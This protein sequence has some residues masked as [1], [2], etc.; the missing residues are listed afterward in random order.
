MFDPYPDNPEATSGSV[1]FSKRRATVAGDGWNPENYGFKADRG[2]KLHPLDMPE[3]VA[4]H[5]RLMGHYVRELERQTEN[6]VEM[7]VDEDFY[8]HIQW[9]Q[10]EL[11]ELAAR[12]QAPLVFNLI[13]TSVNWVLGS[14]RRATMDYKILPR[15]KEG[16]A[17]AERKGEL[18]RY[19][20]DENRSEYEHSRAFASAVKAG[21]GWIETGQGSPDDGVMVFDRAESWRSILWDSLAQRPDLLDGRYIFRSKWLDVDV[22]KALIPTGRDPI[23]DHA[24][25]EVV[26]GLA[27]LDDL[28]DD[29][30]DSAEASHFSSANLFGRSGHHAT[31]RSRVRVV[32]AW[33]KRIERDAQIVRGG[34]FNGQLFDPWSEGQHSEISRGV[35]H[36]VQRPREV[37]WVALMTE[38][39]LLDLRRSPYRHNRWPFTPVWGYRRER[40][41]MPYGMI[42]GMR[43]INRDLNKR[44]SKALHLLSSVRV[45]AEKGSVDDIEVLRDEAARPDAVIEYNA[46][47]TP[48]RLETDHNLAAAQVDLM[49]RDAMM[50]QQVAGVTDENLGRRTNAASGKAI[51]ARQDQGQLATSHFF[52]NLRLARAIHGEK[53]VCN[54]EQFYSDQDEFRITNSRGNPE[55]VTVNDGKPENAIALFKA[56]YI[57]TEEDWRASARQAQAEELLDLAGKLAATAPQIVISILDLVVEAMDVPKRDEFVKRIRQVTGAEDPDA[58]P[59]NPDPETLAKKQAQAEESAMNMRALMAELQEKEAKGRKAQADAAKAEG[60]IATDQIALLK[61][62]MET[63]MAIAGAP[64]VAAAADQILG[65]AVQSAAATLTSPQ[66]EAAA[67]MAQA[68]AMPEQPMP[69]APVDPAAQVMPEPPNPAMEGQIQ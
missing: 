32:E 21:L 5:D 57:I 27:E 62:A 59:N 55:Y 17:S 14:Q 20:R 34:Q 69:E 61:Q 41:G 25:A 9:S 42:R 3:A 6:R 35:A 65:Q 60:S 29:A 1:L 26:Y 7:A 44:A 63:A 19:L 58:D 45:Y 39:G 38:A 51:V 30:M 53:L 15:K 28:G 4:M 47:R 37:I 33:F 67:A 23:I 18:L 22:A 31:D 12:G 56:D 40:D 24:S 2:V 43:D 13:Q 52:D 66:D 11:E 64:A 68:P 16:A 36:I 8:D 49:S 48:P 50:L 46:G 10:E 54:V